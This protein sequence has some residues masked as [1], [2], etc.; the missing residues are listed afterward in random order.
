MIRDAL[1]GRQYYWEQHIGPFLPKIPIVLLLLLLGLLSI[2]FLVLLMLVLDIKTIGL[3][4]VYYWYC[5]VIVHYQTFLINGSN[6][7]K[8]SRIIH[9]IKMK[10][11]LTAKNVSYR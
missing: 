10:T 4:S 1:F 3:Y 7:W 8:V 5:I 11:N 6:Q 9:I 2:L